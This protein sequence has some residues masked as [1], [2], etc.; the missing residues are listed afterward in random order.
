MPLI[1]LVEDNLDMQA[2]LR[3]LLEWDGYEVICGASGH[4]ALE[5]LESTPRMPDAII[6]DLRM[7]HMDGV[8]L[9]HT[10]RAD[11]RWAHIRFFMMSANSD[12]DRLKGEDAALMDGLLSK[13]FSLEE[14]RHR[15]RS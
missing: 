8:T 11:Q 15:L 10:V 13:P 7:P 4:D 5:A 9:L 2:V 12:D 3:E 6:S 1:L 14:F